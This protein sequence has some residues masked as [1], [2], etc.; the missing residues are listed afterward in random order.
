MTRLS[1]FSATGEVHCSGCHWVSRGG[2][3]RRD[4]TRVAGGYVPVTTATGLDLSLTQRYLR[5]SED[6]STAALSPLGFLTLV[7]GPSGVSGSEEGVYHVTDLPGPTQDV[8][9]ESVHPPR[10]RVVPG[11]SPVIPT[12]V[13]TESEGTPGSGPEFF[14]DELDVLRC[15]HTSRP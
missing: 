13:G 4:R 3:D 12:T 8:A 7:L 6:L 14:S 10:D 9:D 5:S 11:E 15:A 1:S 2:P